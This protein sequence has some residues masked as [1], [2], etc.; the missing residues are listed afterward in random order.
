MV[1]EMEA[2]FFK[3]A[4]SAKTNDLEGPVKQRTRKTN[5]E[6]GGDTAMESNIKCGG[7]MERLHNEVKSVKDKKSNSGK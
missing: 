1:T 4:Y 7:E 6:Q 3:R 2:E 5:A